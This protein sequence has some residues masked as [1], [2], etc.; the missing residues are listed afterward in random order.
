[1]GSKNSSE[2]FNE[3][4]EAIEGGCYTGSA[5]KVEFVFSREELAQVRFYPASEVV[6]LIE[7]DHPDELVAA[8]KRCRLVVRDIDTLA[9]A[10]LANMYASQ[11][12]DAQVKPPLILNYANPL[13]PYEATSGGFESQEG[14]LCRRT[15]LFAS[16]S[17]D[18]AQPYYASCENTHDGLYSHAML[19]SPNVEAFRDANANALA[20]PMCVA[21]LSA[22][23]PYAPDLED[24]GR[25]ALFAV[26]KTRILG[27]LCVA[28]D[29]G[30]DRLVFGPWGCDE[31]SNDPQTMA[32]AFAEALR[33]VRYN[34]PDGRTCICGADGLFERIVFAISDE[35]EDKRVLKAFV[36]HLGYFHSD[37]DEQGSRRRIARIDQHID[38]FRG[39]LI[40]GA[41]GDALG[42]PVEFISYDSICNRYGG[43]GIRCSDAFDGENPALISD[44]T[45]MTLFTAAGVLSGAA[46]ASLYG[47]AGPVQTYVRD[48][49][50]DWLSTQ[51]PL[52]KGNPSTTWLL[53]VDELHNR[54][55]P[56]TTCIASLREGGKGTLDNLVNDH[57]GCGGVM[58]VAPWGLYARDTSAEELVRTGAAL[59]AITHGHP[60]GW[61]PA[62]AL[63][64]IVNRC[65]FGVESGWADP[66][67][68]LKAIVLECAESLETWFP[69]HVRDARVVADLLMQAVLLCDSDEP[70]HKCI[71]LLGEGWVAE[72]TL[73]IAVYAALRHATDFSAAV[74]AAVNHGGDSDSTG[75]VCGNIMGALL[76]I[77][78]IDPALVEG[79][80]LSATILQVADDLCRD[81]KPD[82]FGQRH[83]DA[84]LSRYALSASEVDVPE[85]LLAD[86]ADEVAEPPRTTNKF[87]TKC[88]AP[89]VEGNKFCTKC[90]QPATND[91]N[92]PELPQL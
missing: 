80:E 20:E 76:G 60:Q 1:M 9:G 47:T 70:D 23:A 49:Y 53:D 74:E 58:R 38:K 73:A 35:S 51:D 21:V 69:D 18:D 77:D 41:I 75:A 63:S 67:D 10:E 25:D 78:A 56:G 40:G 24:F 86:I 88:G 50:L 46:S 6:R 26:I 45:Q 34:S 62:G 52:F 3:T 39:C 19:L 32:R 5:G 44:D 90:G 92:L 85:E 72:E 7:R 55:A 65:A 17:S 91:R 61:I 13:G 87:C 37:P 22:T 48:A 30:Y 11:N 66:F 42:Y 81:G 71:E 36:E 27:M 31:A 28:A 82:E 68:E 15:T 4:L 8:D 89:I 29:N 16:L 12:D 83:D 84:W 14:N 57:K 64:F 54:R 59:A 79:V 33:E 43:G 2:V